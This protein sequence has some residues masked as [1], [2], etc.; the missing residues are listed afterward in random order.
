MRL[1]QLPFLH[2]DPPEWKTAA[3]E[4]AEREAKG[5]DGDGRQRRRRRAAVRPKKSREA[6]RAI[7]IGIGVIVAV[8]VVQAVL[9][10]VFGLPGLSVVVGWWQ[11]IGE[12]WQD[13]P[14]AP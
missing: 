10:W 1:P 7:V 6:A 5:P 4:A 9:T 11:A 8:L 3:E 2:H 13:T 12:H 14:V